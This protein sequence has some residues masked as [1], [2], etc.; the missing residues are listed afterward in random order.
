[1]EY[2]E[3]C[4]KKIGNENV[5]TSC[6]MDANKL[7]FLGPGVPLFFYY[8]RMVILLLVLMMIVFM[9][10]ALFSN[11]TTNDCTSLSSCNSSIFNYISLINKR[12][13]SFYLSIQCYLELLFI[14]V[15]ILFL[16][17]LRLKGRELKKECDEVIDSPSD[18]AVILRRLP[19]KT[20][21]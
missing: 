19:P 15:V 3:C 8:L 7:S 5:D 6:M 14:I 13:S 11:I 4:E 12:S 9:G 16:Q 21:E 2:C 1:M 20:T 18:Y 10:F 17:W